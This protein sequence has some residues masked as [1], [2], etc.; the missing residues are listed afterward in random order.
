M[1]YKA[2]KTPFL[3]FIVKLEIIFLSFQPF[4][5]PSGA[6]SAGLRRPQEAGEATSPL[7]CGGVPLYPQIQEHTVFIF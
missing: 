1:P 6:V 7:E 5:W 3:V 2:L 4:H